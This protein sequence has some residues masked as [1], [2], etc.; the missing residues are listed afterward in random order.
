MV[1]NYYVGAYWPERPEPLEEYARRASVF[2]RH[3]AALDP[4]LVR[5]FEQASSREAALR[6][7]FTTDTETLLGLFNKQKYRRDEGDVS[8]AAWNGESESSSVVSFSCGSPSPY[9]VDCCILTP[10]MR[11]PVAERLLSASMVAQVLRAMA[12]AWEP[13]WSVAT[14]EVHRDMVSED[15]AVGTFVGWG[16]YF[17]RERGSVPPLP[18]PV[19]IEP[20]EDLGTLVILTPERFTATNPAHV[21][22]AAHVQGLLAQ[23]GLLKPLQPLPG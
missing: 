23:S 12:L 10:P 7:Q 5:W 20:V 21:A 14:S 4:T 11:G 6:S 22:L 16:M 9:V 8:F 18:A 19:R 1:E 3:L 15:A 2:M 17:S 13:E